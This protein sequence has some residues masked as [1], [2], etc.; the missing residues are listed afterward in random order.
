V[1]V[2][3]SANLKREEKTSKNTTP[4][5]IHRGS[6]E[7][8]RHGLG[9]KSTGVHWKEG[10]HDIQISTHVSPLYRSGDLERGGILKI[11]EQWIK[12]KRKSQARPPRGNEE[13]KTQRKYQ[14]KVR[15]QWVQK[16]QSAH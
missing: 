3:L 5:E 10:V 16:L 12:G 15:L 7:M 14:R 13:T 11:R 6:G 9:I 1:G 8:H 4:Q 2:I